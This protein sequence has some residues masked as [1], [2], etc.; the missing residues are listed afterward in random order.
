MKRLSYGLLTLW[1]FASLNVH[2]QSYYLSSSTGDDTKDGKT[3]ATAWK[4]LTRYHQ[5]MKAKT[6]KT[7]DDIYFKRGDTFQGQVYTT[8]ISGGTAQDPFTF[9]A[10]GDPKL[11]N[12]IITGL[13]PIKQWQAVQ[14]NGTQACVADIAYIMNNLSAKN[15]YGGYPIDDMLAGKVQTAPT[16]LL[17]EGN[18]QRLARYPNDSY[19]FV[20]EKSTGVTLL[21]TE[22][23]GVPNLQGWVGGQVA[24]RTSNWDYRF[25]DVK[26]ITGTTMKLADE[27][28]GNLT[29]RNGYF[30]MNK[31]IGLDA[32]G[33]WFT[34]TTAKKIYFIPPPPTKC[35]ELENKVDASVFESG[36][37][38]TDYTTIQDLTFS[39]YSDAAIFFSSQKQQ[40]KSLRNKVLNTRVGVRGSG[41]S[42]VEVSN[43]EMRNIFGEAI[44]FWPAT[45]ATIS[46]N[47]IENVGIYPAV[48]GSYNAIRFGSDNPTTSIKNVIS[49]NV[50]RNVGYSGIMFR[51]GSGKAGEESVIEKNVIERALATLADGGGIY[52]QDCNGNIIRDNIIFD[53]YGNKDSWREG[54]GFQDYT[55][56]AFG[57]VLFLDNNNGNQILHNTIYNTDDGIHIGSPIKNNVIKDNVLYNNR[58]YQMSVAMGTYTGTASLNYTVTNNI[59]YAIDPNQWTL[60]QTKRDQKNWLFGTFD[61]NFYGHPY[62]NSNYARSIGIT[63]GVEL[64]RLQSEDPG[65]L[66]YS[67]DTWK[68]AT[69]QDKNSKTDAEK[70]VALEIDNKLYDVAQVLSPNL[71]SNS[72]FD[73]TATPWEVTAGAVTVEKRASMDGSAL[74]LKNDYSDT[75]SRVNNGH[76]IA[77]EK[78]QYY[79]LSFSTSRDTD[80]MVRVGVYD[81]T[82][83]KGFTQLGGRYIFPSG[84]KSKNYTYLFKLDQLG[85]DMRVYFLIEKTDADVWVDNVQ[86]YK[87]SL[88]EA[89]PSKER[90]KLFVNPSAAPRTFAL[91]GNVYKDLNGVTVK[92]A[93]TVD[94]YSS[95]ILTFVSTTP[96]QRP[97][98][99][100]FFMNLEGRKVVAKWSATNATGYKLYYVP[101]PECDANKLASMDMGPATSITLESL[102]TGTTFY[103]TVTA[104]NQYGESDFPIFNCIG[105]A[106]FFI[107]P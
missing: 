85:T 70:W 71:I 65:T 12:P 58:A 54:K 2:A 105:E 49:K 8:L 67:L 57:I 15:Q 77:F 20:D 74:H 96:G 61:N 33:E 13:Q 94:P 23:S 50:I 86:L 5:A 31:L 30:F 97:G 3:E 55:A 104:Y 10:Y 102:P 1:L 73:A 68:T 35:A 76:G 81:R 34:D 79:Q 75:L 64:Y 42:F 28:I 89:M 95:K 4:T 52:L 88:K 83:T 38:I 48:K 32:P 25:T 43:N 39:G 41:V 7:S 87:V 9:G 103:A 66:V 101:Y 106:N 14:V 17:F 26:S 60:G 22:L 82:S 11:P 91:N 92:D 40:M 18:L 36:I 53:T 69:G 21:D 44:V 46:G 72:T 100:N 99:P 47:L 107:V 62:Y 59:M 93:V 45:N 90:S 63:S 6:F 24:V 51:V 16:N 80:G 19:L 78:D 37:A 27:I 98:V 29:I 84:P 56:Y